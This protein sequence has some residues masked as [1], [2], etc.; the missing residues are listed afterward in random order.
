MPEGYDVKNKWFLIILFLPF[1]IAIACQ[2]KESEPKKPKPRTWTMDESFLDAIVSESGCTFTWKDVQP[3]PP[4]AQNIVVDSMSIVFQ[5]TEFELE[6]GEPAPMAVLLAPGADHP[7]TFPVWIW[8]GGDP[9]RG[10][11]EYPYIRIPQ[12]DKQYSYIGSM[13][14]IEPPNGTWTLTMMSKCDQVVVNRLLL[15]FDGRYR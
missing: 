10:R 11:A 4:A 15:S 6:M 7:D 2:E 3:V 13:S 1:V 5:D 8:K 12:D 9:E 14:S